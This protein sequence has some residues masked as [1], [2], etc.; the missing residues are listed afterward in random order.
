MFFEDVNVKI[1]D[2]K[3]EVF[4]LCVV[5]RLIMKDQVECMIVVGMEVI[6]VGVNVFFVDKEIFFGLIVD[7]VDN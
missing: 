1:W 3:V 5:F 7:F 6:L 4:V 2:L